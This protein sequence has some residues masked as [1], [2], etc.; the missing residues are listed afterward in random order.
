M[1]QLGRFKRGDLKEETT[2]RNKKIEIG[3]LTSKGKQKLKW[4]IRKLPYGSALGTPT[5]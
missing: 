3:K 2:T 5:A 4:K 1:L